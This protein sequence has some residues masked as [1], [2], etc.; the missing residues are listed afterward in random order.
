MADITLRGY[1]PVSP[2]SF[3]ISHPKKR[4][5]GKENQGI[6]AKPL[7]ASFGQSNFRKLELKAPVAV[8][9]VEVE[10]EPWQKV[11]VETG[12]II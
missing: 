9:R 11:G 8:T 5:D 4:D 6:G 3:N 7:S 1:K 10:L 12:A 2:P